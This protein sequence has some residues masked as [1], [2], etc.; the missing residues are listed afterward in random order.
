MFENWNDVE[1]DRVVS[2]FINKWIR[3]IGKYETVEMVV[4]KIVL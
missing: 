3:E 2:T 1:F 4:I